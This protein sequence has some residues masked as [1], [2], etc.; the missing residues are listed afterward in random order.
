MI[1][2]AMRAKRVECFAFAENVGI[3][4][5]TQPPRLCFCMRNLGGFSFSRLVI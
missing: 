4:N 1:G 2:Q 5:S 3:V